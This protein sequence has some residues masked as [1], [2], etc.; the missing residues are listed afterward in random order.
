MEGL[1]LLNFIMKGSVE[2]FFLVIRFII[3]IVGVKYVCFCFIKDI[4]R[5]LVGSDFFFME[6]ISV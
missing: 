5:M 1:R 4:S 3:G 2:L 6:L